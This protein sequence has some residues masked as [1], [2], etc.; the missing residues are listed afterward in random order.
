MMRYRL[1][2]F[3]IL[4]ALIA[5]VQRVALTVPMAHIAGTLGVN[6]A[7]DMGYVQS[8]WYLGYSVMQLPSGWLA[9]RIGSRWALALYCTTWSMCTLASGLAADYTSLLVA[10]TLMGAA[11]A[12]IFPCATKAIQQTFPD[13]ERARAAG[14]LVVGNYAG[15]GLGPLM[16]GMLLGRF[17]WPGSTDW[18][19][20]LVLY[21]LPGLLWPL[22]FLQAI[23]P[24]ELPIRLHVLGQESKPVRL[25]RLLVSLPLMLLFIQQF[26]RA[27][28]MVFFTT[29]FA[30]Y[31][32][33]ARGVSIANSGLLTFYVSISGILGSTLG[34]ICSDAIL[35]RTG[36][37]RLARQGIA[38]VGTGICAL[39]VGV[40]Y[41]VTDSQAAVAI[42]CLGMFCATFGGVSA[43]TM[44]IELGG[45]QV[46]TVFGTMN[47]C[48]N[49]GAMVFPTVV[50]WVV[51]ASGENWSLALFL[52]A[53]MMIVAAACWSMLVPEHR[54]EG[55]KHAPR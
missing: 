7:R 8:A 47:M 21:A 28:A 9:D 16:T 1:L 37:R 23:R 43:F 41:F 53:G 32:Q 30:V 5:Y 15:Q 10:W 19:V 14:L 33:K 17:I 4:A 18:R 39:L 11:Q 13:E 29:W 48:G 22:A 25:G 42:I 24:Q 40:S 46:T 49:L 20:C 38:V 3:L 55:E 36:N 2:A 26:L 51:D 27:G 6:L 44:A 35:A 34:G 45:R 31:L 12:G 52:F 54:T 50:G